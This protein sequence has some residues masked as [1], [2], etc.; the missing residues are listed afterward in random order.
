MAIMFL[1]GHLLVIAMIVL[2]TI[3]FFPL[4][5]IHQLSPN[6]YISEK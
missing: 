3:S 2:I 6:A 5:N 4:A 1:I